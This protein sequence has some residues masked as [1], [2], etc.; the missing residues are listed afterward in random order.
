MRAGHGTRVKRSKLRTGLV[1]CYK[2]LSRKDVVEFG[3]RGFDFQ[4]FE[5]VKIVGTV[6]TYGAGD[7]GMA[8]EQ[9]ERIR[10]VGGASA[11]VAR[12]GV[13]DEGEIDVVKTFAYE[14]IAEAS[15]IGKNVVVSDRAA[16]HDAHD[17]PRD[18]LSFQ[19]K[20]KGAKRRVCIG[21]H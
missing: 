7:D 19:I 13:G 21:F 9:L 8:A 5:T 6:G 17:E 12:H 3:H 2:A 11:V 10:D 1:G 16:D 15:A 18:F 20:S 14:V 4:L